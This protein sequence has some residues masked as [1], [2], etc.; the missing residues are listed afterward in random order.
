MHCRSF[1]IVIIFLLSGCFDRNTP[2]E[3]INQGKAAA[4][5]EH[6]AQAILFYKNALKDSTLTAQASFELGTIYYATGDLLNAE[7]YLQEAFDAKHP[8]EQ[9]VPIL[10]AINFQQNSIV[11][12]KHL[13]NDQKN[14]NATPEFTLQLAFYDVLILARENQL[15]QAQNQFNALMADLNEAEKTCELCLFTQ[16]SLQSYKTPNSAINTLNALSKKHPKSAQ[17]YLLRGQLYFALRNPTE[18]M[19]NFKQFKELQPKAGYVQFLLAITALQMKDTDSATYYVDGL[20]S[21]NPQQPLVNHLKALIVFEQKEYGEAQQY[22]EQ[23]IS[24][25]LKS[26]ANYLIAGVS[27]YH[28]EQMESA[29][30]HL[31]KAVISY[32]ENIQLQRLLM[33]IQVK[34]GYLEEASQSLVEQDIRSVDDVLIGN[35]MAFNFLKEGQFNEAQNVLSYLNNTPISKPIIRLQTQALQNQLN[36]K[37]ALSLSN[38]KATV[39]KLIPEENLIQIILLLESKKLTEAMTIAE[40]WLSQAPEDIDALNALAYVFQQADQ[41]EKSKP[42]FIKAL[43]IKPQNTPSLFFLAQEALLQTKYQQANDYYHAILK[44]N[45]ENLTALRAILKLTFNS[46]KPPNWDDLLSSIDI[47]SLSDDQVVAIADAMFRWKHHDKLDDLLVNYKPQNQWSDMTWMV[48]LKNRYVITDKE[49]FKHDFDNYYQVNSL[50]SHLLFALSILENQQS[51]PL[52]LNI[53]EQLPNEIQNSDVVRMQKAF[54]LVELKQFVQVEKIALILNHN[55][56]FHSSNWYFKGK[57]IEA[58]GDLVQAANHFF[59]YYEALPSFHSVNNLVTIL[60]KEKRNEEAVNVTQ[61]YLEQFPND[62]SSYVSLGLKLAPIQPDVALKLLE[63]EQ[64]QW[65]IWRNWKLSHN[66]AWLYLSQNKP[67]KAVTYSTNALALNTSNEQL[68]VLHA[69]VLNALKL[70]KRS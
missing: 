34:F 21:G 9:V 6:Y 65:L 57:V 8:A 54:A 17:A 13:L 45:P 24:R 67:E 41:P 60:I 3:Y 40:Q 51:Y 31:R 44:I 20:L 7:R 37:E 15:K 27:A 64:V 42:L 16:A 68:K 36:L 5:K 2:E 38:P 50:E 55:P 22:A 10:A 43:K 25:G 58:Q 30:S 35:L 46:Q 4:A 59:S 49:N 63:N 47:K 62:T 11:A 33:L 61:E 29:Y 26:P 48:W 70:Q 69:K 52:M 32:P 1:F 39:Q 53:I 19:K 23:S 28:Q 18:A 12:L 14:K 66:M 56:D